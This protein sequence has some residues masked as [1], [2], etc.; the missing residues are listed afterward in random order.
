[1]ETYPQPQ[2]PDLSFALPI[3][4]YY[5]LVHTF[6]RI[7]PPP[8]ADT[9]EAVRARDHAAMDAVAAMLPTNAN[10]AGLAAQCVATRAQADEA[11]RLMRVHAGDIA[12]VMKLQ[13]Q[14]VALVRASLGAGGHLRRTQA[15]RHK[16]EANDSTLKADEWTQH[17]A[18]S[19]MQQALDAGVGPAT[20]VASAAGQS[21]P[22]VEPTGTA[23]APIREATAELPAPTPEPA[24]VA[25][26]PAPFP[27]TAPPP[28]SVAAASR[29]VAEPPPATAST[30]PA[31]PA[32]VAAYPPPQAAP[33][34]AA[35][36][37][38]SPR[39]AAPPQADDP[40]RDLPAEADYYA[41]VYPNRAREIRQHDG[42]PPN[43]SYGPP[44]DDL[45][46]AIVTGTTPH[47]RALD[48]VNAAAD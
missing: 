4:A 48:R 25:H 24:P 46:L 30:L 11:M 20:P 9:P 15:V 16:R 33:E 3:H 45:V 43:C 29:P 6:S 1:M 34:P 26:S 14:Y 41:I 10:E 40:Q 5:Q 22:A 32:P 27:A 36:P 35:A 23:P 2:H 39:V 38:R 13:A 44:D 37:P 7:L 47:L 19:L 28:P 8:V 31:V 42:L 12:V 17:I 18:T 21:A